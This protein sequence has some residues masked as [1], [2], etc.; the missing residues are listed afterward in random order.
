MSE[1]PSSRQHRYLRV[2]KR[3]I[4]EGEMIDFDLYLA[5]DAKT[6]MT[7]FLQSHSVVDGN[8]KVR[9]R[10]IEA[11][12]IS[13]EEQ[14]Q[15][16]NFV[17]AHL[18]SVAKNPDI[19]IEEKAA[20]IYNVATEA[21]EKI[22]TQPESPENVKRSKQVVSALVDSILHDT[23][24]IES[25]LRVTAHDYYTH[26]HSLNVS[27]Y[28]LSLGLFLKLS[29]QDM[30]EL[31][32]AALLHDLGK[33]KVAY[34]IINKNGRL[35]DDEFQQMKTHPAHGHSIAIKMGITNARI[36][37]GIRYHHEKMD[38]L[39]YPDGIGSEGLSLFPRIIGVCDVFDA[40]TT[41][42]SYK[43][44]MSSFEALSLMK[45]EMK[46]HLDVQMVNGFIQMLHIK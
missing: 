20:L 46:T 16:R 8:A 43:E 19:P 26:T 17:Q 12:Y 36:L 31:G 11:L 32:Q 33:S 45:K 24:A 38:G 25:L 4:T 37:E 28:A 2:D 14:P 27:I 7:T 21:I 42:R 15:Y 10:E 5:D 29:E 41:R 23:K 3:L 39:G 18:Q 13:E 34:E 22:F 40:L 9:L 30:I 35:S 6:H 1:Q 44:P